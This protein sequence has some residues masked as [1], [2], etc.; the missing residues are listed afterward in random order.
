VRG[1]LD[2]IVAH[3]LERDPLARYASVAELAADVQRHL[4]GMPVRAGETTLR[5]GIAMPMARRQR[6]RWIAA[7]AVA[8]ALVAALAWLGVELRT[9]R[10]EAD[11][12][13]A[14]RVRAE[15]V[16][17]ILVGWLTMPRDTTRGVDLKVADWLDDSA[18]QIAADAALP[19]EA[20]LALHTLLARAYASL[21]RDD[22]A[23]AQVELGLAQAGDDAP[24]RLPLLQVQATV[25]ALQCKPA[26]AER[27]IQLLRDE[28]TAAG[29]MAMQ[30]EAAVAAARLADCRDDFATQQRE[31][32]TALNLT[33]DRDDAVDVRGAAAELL[34][35]AQFGQGDLDTA[36]RTLEDTLAHWPANQPTLAARQ[37]TLRHLLLQLSGARGDFATAE[38]LARDNLAAYLQRHGKAPHPSTISA[39]SALASILYDRGDLDGAL[40]EN[41]RALADAIAFHGTDAEAGL[42][43]A[44]NRANV[45]KS[46]GR[47]DE[48][49]AEYRRVIAALAQLANAPGIGETRLIHSFN[50]LELLNERGRF[51]DAKAFGDDVLAEAERVLGREH[52]VT[53]ET[54][55]ALGVTALGLGDAK[56]AEPATKV[57]A[58]ALAIGRCCRPSRRRRSRAGSRGR[59]RVDATAHRAQLV[60]RAGNELLAAE[61]R[62]HRHDQHQVE[63][64][65]VWS[66][67]LSGV[68]GLNTRPAWQPCSP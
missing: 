6:R 36:A 67:Q 24:S 59:S 52:I 17:R 29:V 66:S 31:A 56:I 16:S 45:L 68:A 49:E 7:L 37:A 1:D 46:L 42:L 22:D 19:H 18:R 11:A 34:A 5:T 33:R 35:R 53:L 62:V 9:T 25:S 10:A 38:R 47:L 51:R 3:T 2:A 21:G 28:A 58:P 54:R 50:L 12:A 65:S 64:C 61:A 48:A 14:A 41:D 40:A 15:A 27:A 4:D 44:A 20:R 55:D 26:A 13:V 30:A 39:R 60:E 23:L 63:L 8:L 43:I 57:S 32:E